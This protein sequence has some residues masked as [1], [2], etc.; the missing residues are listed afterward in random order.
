M[1]SHEEF[2]L[3]AQAMSSR[4]HDPS[5][6]V[7]SVIVDN[8]N[9]VALGFNHVP[10]RIQFTQKQIEDRSWKYPRVIHAE[11]DAI[12]KL[13]KQIVSYPIMYTTHYPCSAC[14]TLIVESGIKEIY[15][16][17]IPID[18]LERWGESMKLSSQI[19]QEG[20]VFVNYLDG[21]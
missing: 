20:G 2:M 6:K 15:T 1:S 13:G 12:L 3:I 21:P 18:M 14:A 19:L 11:I 10:Q 4:S 5:T 9:I 7:G 8:G 17:K 16:H